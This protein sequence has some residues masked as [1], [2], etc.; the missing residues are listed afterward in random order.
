MRCR[1]GDL[2]VIVR[3]KRNDKN[4]GILV[5]VLRPSWLMANAWHVESIGRPFHLI[6]RV[7]QFGHIED[8][9]L[10]P[11]GNPGDDATDET[12]TWLDVPSKQGEPA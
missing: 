7:D 9:R 4:I 12:L 2:A 5:H 8:A 1:V 6:D 11:I 10:L 3:P